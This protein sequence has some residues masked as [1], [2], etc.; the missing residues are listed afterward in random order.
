MKSKKVFMVFATNDFIPIK[1]KDT[2]EEAEKCI[3]DHA[4]MDGENAPPF[5]IIETIKYTKE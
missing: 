5:Y 4:L 1:D 2:Q 3:Q